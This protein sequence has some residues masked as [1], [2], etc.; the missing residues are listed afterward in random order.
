MPAQSGP[1]SGIFVSAAFSIAFLG[2][3]GDEPLLLAHATTAMA[4]ATRTAMRLTLMAT[5]ISNEG[6][7]V[8]R[9]WGSSFTRHVASHDGGPSLWETCL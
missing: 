4:T 3:S 2:T 6:R 7:A 1:A 5:S 9:W 8:S